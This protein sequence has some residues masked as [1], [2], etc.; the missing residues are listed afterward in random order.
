MSDLL[1][2]LESLRG[3]DAADVA[4]ILGAYLV[5]NLLL[6]PATP[7]N[8]ICGYLGGFGAG[9]GIAAPTRI[10]AAA[11][12]FILSRTVL[13]ARFER[14]VATRPRMRALDGALGRTGLRAVTL[15]RLSP[16]LPSSLSS[17]AL[18]ATSVRGR[19]FVCGTAIGTLPSTL[20]H[21]SI[22]AGLASM[23]DAFERDGVTTAEQILLWS[24]V[25][26]TALVLWLLAR[27]ARAELTRLA[28]GG[29]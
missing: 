26:A 2:A 10:V 15:L 18:G 27:R 8:M 6:V 4:L 25:V 7:L 28:G 13:R 16:L 14:I 12:A 11:A 29:Q 17:Y 24:G 22:G 5:A 20:L 21:V 19:D 9:L 23:R 3:P 1:T